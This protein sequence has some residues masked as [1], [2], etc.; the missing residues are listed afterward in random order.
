MMLAKPEIE[1]GWCIQ[2]EAIYINYRDGTVLCNTQKRPLQPSH[3]VSL[4][5]DYMS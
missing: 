3:A 1:E 4:G 2:L 5:E